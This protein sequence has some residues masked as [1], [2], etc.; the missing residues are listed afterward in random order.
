MGRRW[1][2]GAALAAVFAGCAAVRPAAAA[3]IDLQEALQE[4]VLGAND[5]PVTMAEYSSLTC[6]HCADF[7]T[8]TFPQLK[9]EYVDTGKLKVVYR[10]FPHDRLA[11]FASILAHCAAPK[12]FFGFLDVLFRDQRQWMDLSDSIEAL[13]R[14]GRLGGVNDERFDA[15]V[16]SEA[17]FKGLLE[18][19]LRA[20]N[21]YK[22][23][24]TPTFVF[25]EGAERVVG[26]QPVEAFRAV[27]ERLLAAAPAASSASAAVPV[28]GGGQGNAGAGGQPAS[29]P[30]A[31][32]PAPAPAAAMPATVEEGER[33]KEGAGGGVPL[34]LDGAA[35][36]PPQTPEAGKADGGNG[37]GEI[38][39]PAE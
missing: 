38:K 8:K 32:V 24:V 7:H 23:D 37:V 18:I 5:A 9:A 35:G 10:D 15:C 16:G 33:P 13:R 17:L 20:I 3:D 28:T 6:P 1:L 21:D 22:I 27:I 4:R 11:L 30:A 26:A 36:A 12:R 14:V 19:R 25:N 31:G 39:A 34:P 29:A 2:V